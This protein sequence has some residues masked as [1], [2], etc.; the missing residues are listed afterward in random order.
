M[1]HKLGRACLSKDG[2]GNR[3]RWPHASRRIAAHAL[4]F[5]WFFLWSRCDAPQHE[6]AT[7][8]AVSELKWRGFITRRRGSVVWQPATAVLL[9]ILLTWKAEARTCICWWDYPGPTCAIVKPAKSTIRVEWAGITHRKLPRLSTGILG[10]LWRVP[11]LG[12]AFKESI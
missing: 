9:S 7:E 4:G 6:A 10:R 8:S 12:G 11:V 2:G 3:S 1:R 5:W